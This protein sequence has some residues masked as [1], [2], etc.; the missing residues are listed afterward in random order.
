[1]TNGRPRGTW[2]VL[3]V[4]LA[5]LVVQ[6]C[7]MAADTPAGHPCPHC[8]GEASETHAAHPGEVA[9]VASCDFVDVYSL[10]SRGIK[11]GPR[12]VPLDIPALPADI[13]GPAVLPVKIGPRAHALR[14]GISPHHPPLN[15][16]NCVYLK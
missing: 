4:A 5:N 7:A 12:D 15:V 13:A 1:M 11:S 2:A 9:E 14:F 16:L 6:P 3:L 10:E 8:P